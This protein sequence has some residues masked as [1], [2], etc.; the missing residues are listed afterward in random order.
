MN[1]RALYLAGCPVFSYW[2]RNRP[3]WIVMGGRHWQFI[4]NNSLSWLL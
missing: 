3:H 4:S 2:H 1:I